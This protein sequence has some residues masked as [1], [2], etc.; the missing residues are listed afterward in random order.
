MK[1]TR[2]M[3]IACGLVVIALWFAPRAV[4]Q[5][6]TA[7]ISG[8]ITDS[9]G[10]VVPSAEVKLQSVDRG[11][12]ASGITNNAG[13]YV[14]AS[15][16]PGPY[17]ITVQKPG[18]KQVDFL[19]LIVN[20]QDHI[21]QNFRLQVGSI[22]ESITVTGNELN[23]N[24]T[25]A[26]VSTVVDRQFVEN[27][28]LNGRSFQSLL[29]LTPGIVI[30]PEAITNANGQFSVNGQR[31][32]A[33][34]FTVDGVSANFG[35]SPVAAPGAQT[36]GS[37]P[38]LTTFGTT[39][40][41]V[42]V[43]AMQEFRVQTST[44]SAE[45]G[46]Q[47]GGQISIVTRSG[48]NSFHGSLFDYLR[49]DVFDA[50][51]WFADRA[52]QPKPP[53]K[54]NDFGGTFGGPVRIPGLYN[55]KDKTFFFFSYE[56]LR[57]RQPRFLLT[58]VP[59]IALRHNAPASLQPLMNSFPLPNDKDLGNGLA[60]ATAAYSDPSSL[61]ATSIRIDHKLNQ[62]WNIFGRY[63]RAPSAST[64]RGLGSLSNITVNRLLTQTGTVGITAGITPHISN[65][66]RANYSDNRGPSEVKID[67]FGGAIPPPRSALIPSQYDSR[68]AQA[69]YVL[70]FPGQTAFPITGT[71]GSFVSTQRQ[72][73]VID[74]VSYQVGSHQIKFGVDYRRLT[75]VF[76]ANSYDL[77]VTF[78]SQ[79]EVL[80]GQVNAGEGGSAF[81]A[82]QASTK[83]I[84][85]NFSAYVED[86][87]KVSRR[88]TLDLGLRWDV[89]PAPGEGTANHPLGVTQINNLAT[90]QLAPEG[91]SLWNTTY[92]N[93]APRLG[94][95]YQVSQQPGRETVLRGGFGGFY[96][97]GNNQGSLGF[98]GSFFPFFTFAAFPSVSF[99]LSPAQVAPPTLPNL[100]NLT[101]PYGTIVVF[102]PNLQLPYTWHWNLAFEQALGKNQAL[103]FSYVGDAGRRLL[104]QRQLNLATINT[105]FTTVQLTTNR[106]TSDYDALQVQFQRHLSN[107]LQALASYTLSHA[108]DD[109]SSDNGTIVPVRGN[110]AFDIRHIFATAITYDIPA[111]DN[112]VLDAVLGH[113]SADTS[114]HVQT[115]F[116]V[117]ITG[118]QFNNP[119]NGE[120]VA[121]RA[122]VVPGVPFYV[123]D[124][125][126]PGGRRINGAAF[127]IPAAGQFGNLGR[128][129]VRGLRAW[130]QDL[131][132]RRLFKLT[133][134][135][136]LQFRAEAFNIFN[137]PNFGAIQTNLSAA[138]FGQATNMLNQQLGGINPLYQIG[139][140]RSAQFALKLI[141]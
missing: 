101:P 20:V 23:V 33:N 86:A 91:A 134:K 55:G 114:F 8:L 44:Y 99:P 111:P 123:D 126:V 5:T 26:S 112:R 87:W 7:T 43:D 37:L 83:P 84:Y 60:E 19:G 116:P 66:F 75:P 125:T 70:N 127:T 109:D 28:P 121:A 119:A 51:D 106:A 137:H 38:G 63:N 4:G 29:T 136:N 22:S 105:N 10:A 21:E 73:N 88:V 50:N 108:L 16:H 35:S 104:Q 120:L 131:A 18:F 100:T 129:V 27:I 12:T 113:W 47:P 11:T 103:T 81:V 141:F 79:Q 41:L 24:T 76:A 1:M 140:P 48:T 128:N 85:V 17:Q 115:A 77:G 72:F 67:N 42:S 45:Y 64:T 52:G 117:D 39:Q 95:A 122:N 82:V 133:D 74:N 31:P 61:N 80:N 9:T 15:V 96:D 139:G 56:G 93:F 98:N 71:T 14:F 2:L 94:L 78:A 30:V 6:E 69:T 92:D 110:S 89:N 68:T 102:D 54:Q 130:Q 25:D 107:G 59:T 135:L 124:P 13:I 62:K 34:S 40:S 65:D 138:N 36:S 46:R 49:N 97:T 3:H 118:S 90:M 58:N 132:V 53:E 32:D 57:L